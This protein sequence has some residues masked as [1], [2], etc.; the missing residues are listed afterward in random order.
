MGVGDDWGPQVISTPTYL[1]NFKLTIA[2]NTAARKHLFEGRVQ[3]LG[4]QNRL[5]DV[6]PYLITAMFSNFPGES[7]TTKVV[8]IE[9]DE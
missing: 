9:M 4:Q 3:S 1:R 2:E 7:G 6:M 5:P 8:T